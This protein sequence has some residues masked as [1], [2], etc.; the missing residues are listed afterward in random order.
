MNLISGDFDFFWKDIAGFRLKRRQTKEYSCSI[1]SN[2]KTYCLKCRRQ[3]PYTSIDSTMCVA[4]GKHVG[5][6]VFFG[7]M[8]ILESN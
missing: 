5:T 7:K 1:L 6:L 3:N 2:A 4:N 8:L